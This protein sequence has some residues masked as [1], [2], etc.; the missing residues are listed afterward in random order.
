MDSELKT[1]LDN[2]S[3]DIERLRSETS[4]NFRSVRA[5]LNTLE[6][7]VL[8]IAQKLLAEAEVEEIRANMKG[9]KVAVG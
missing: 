9:K 6:Y 3:R 7:G 1:T 4:V 5:Q 2:I 8:T